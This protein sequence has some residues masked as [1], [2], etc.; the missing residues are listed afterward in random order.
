MGRVMARDG[1]WLGYL[2]FGEESKRD[3]G[4]ATDDNLVCTRN[5]GDRAGLGTEGSESGQ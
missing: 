1:G 5:R 4:C 2:E 3:G